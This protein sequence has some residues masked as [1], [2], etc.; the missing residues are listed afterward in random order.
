MA[1]GVMNL[2]IGIDIGGT[3]IGAGLLDEDLNI[4]YRIEIP[5]SKDRGYDFVESQIISIIEDM[6]SKASKLNHKID[7]IGIG[8][9]GIV[10]IEGNNVIYNANLN[11]NNVPLGKNLRDRFDIPINIE[12]D[13]TIAGIAESALGV[14]KG[15]SNSVFITLGTGV[16]GGII[17]NHKVYTGSHGLGSE[18]GH[19]IVGENFYDCNCGNNGCLETFIS[20]TAVRRYVINEIEHGFINTSIL[21]NVNSIEEIDTK[22]I[23]ECAELGD[24]LSNKAV[25]RMA[26]YLAIGIANIINIIDPD[27]I[28]IGGGVAKAGDFFLDRVKDL[29]PRYI[30]FKELDFGEI[31]LAKLGNDAGIIGAAMLKE[32]K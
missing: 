8:L 4:I 10:D 21:K 29:L 26:K 32:Y 22:L 15:Y 9:P 5:T 17:I 30:L 19:M 6:I 13:A 20:S 11:W 24:E 2:N 27:I 18:I 28:A 14:M 23:F 12:N 3:N 31:K 1:K 25:N 16:G 7:S